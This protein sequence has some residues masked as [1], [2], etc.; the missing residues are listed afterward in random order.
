MGDSTKWRT[1][2]VKKSLLTNIEKLLDKEK[3]QKL[4]ITNMSQFIDL[5]LKEK[6]EELEKTG[7]RSIVIEGNIIEIFDENLGNDGKL[8]I[9]NH[10]KNKL[11]CSECN[12]KDCPHTNYILSID[13]ISEK[14][15]EKG[16]IRTEKTCPKC[17]VIAK[18]LEIDNIFGYRKNGTRT[19]TQSHCR[20]CRTK[21]KK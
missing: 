6:L 11:N 3:V 2:N 1:V 5:A 16:L 21:H 19:I 14:L 10:D 7:F 12:S 4:G 8:V 20:N 18:Q 9:V 17:G 13:H 15:E